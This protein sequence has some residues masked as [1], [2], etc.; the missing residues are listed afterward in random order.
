MPDT[1]RA[2]TFAQSRIEWPRT[3]TSIVDND[4]PGARHGTSATEPDET[5][6]RANDAEFLDGRLPVQGAIDFR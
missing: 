5:V 3:R 1:H 4:S 6:A 2:F